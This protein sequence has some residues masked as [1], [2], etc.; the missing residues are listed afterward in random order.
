MREMMFY[1]IQIK[2]TKRFFIFQ[3]EFFRVQTAL[4][5]GSTPVFNEVRSARTNAGEAFFEIPFR[6]AFLI[7]FGMLSAKLSV[8][9][10]VMV[11]IVFV[12]NHFYAIIY[13]LVRVEIKNI[14]R[15]RLLKMLK[16]APT[17]RNLAVFESMEYQSV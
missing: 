13:D 9:E 3:E 16:V 7:G 12:V 2:G 4:A 10:H 14:L 6:A 11:A 1:L 8:P 15:L 17:E 5:S